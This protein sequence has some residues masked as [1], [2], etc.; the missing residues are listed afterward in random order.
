MSKA[1]I[2]ELDLKMQQVREYALITHGYHN[3]NLQYPIHVRRSHD[4]EK[5][6][7]TSSRHSKSDGYNKKNR[8]L[9]STILISSSHENRTKIKQKDLSTRQLSFDQ[10]HTTLIAPPNKTV[11]DINPLLNCDRLHIHR[12]S[13]S[14]SI[15]SSPI[16]CSSRPHSIAGISHEQ[17][18]NSLS[19][20]SQSLINQSL[21][22]KT[23]TQRFFSKLFHHP[24]KS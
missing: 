14:S 3:E 18:I 19:N 6:A 11:N 23:L 15:N 24:S 2:D 17:K 1:F 5:L 21:P 4:G 20:S 9:N 7:R 22:T 8:F 10:R 16:L 12:K 13:S